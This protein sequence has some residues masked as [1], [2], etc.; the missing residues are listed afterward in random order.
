MS[1]LGVLDLSG[2]GQAANKIPGTP[3]TQAQQLQQKQQHFWSGYRRA[4]GL[5]PAAAALS[6]SQ[7]RFQQAYPLVMAQRMMAG[8]QQ[9]AY[10]DPLIAQ[11]TGISPDVGATQGPWRVRSQYSPAAYAASKGWIPG[12]G[13]SADVGAPWRNRR[14][15]GVRAKITQR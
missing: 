10:S 14:V 13:V 8:R 6:F 12:A 11:Q 7:G 2:Y 9:T 5:I 4:P 1:E 15:M 3:P